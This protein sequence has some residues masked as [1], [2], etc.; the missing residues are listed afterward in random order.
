MVSKL[1]I[2]AHDY[3]DDSL[4]VALI[5]VQISVTKDLVDHVGK[6]SLRTLP[7]IAVRRSCSLRYLVVQLLQFAGSNARGLQYVVILA[8]R[9]TVTWTK[10]AVPNVRFSSPKPACAAKRHSRTCHAGSRTSSAVRSAVVSSNADLTSAKSRA[11][12]LES[13][14]TL[15]ANASNPVG[16]PRKFAGTA[17]KS[18]A[19][20]LRHVARTSHVRAR[21]SSH[22]HANIS[23]KK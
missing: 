2:S 18:L 13:A 10:K 14:K 21:C 15:D 4:S 8:F 6:L 23:S 3:A 5:L 16:S 17:V 20:H 1:S 12:D 7:A 22:V 19:M 9:T 11:I